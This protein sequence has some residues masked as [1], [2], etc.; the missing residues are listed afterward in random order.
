MNIQTC[1]SPSQFPLFSTNNT[2]VVVTDILRATSAMCTAFAN[3]IDK[4]IP[5]E[6]IEEAIK[7]KEQGYIVAA[8]RNGKI[9]EGFSLGN[10]PFDYM[11]EML[12]GKT[13]V[14]STTNGTQAIAAAKNAETI[15]IGAFVNIS[16][17]ADFLIHEQKD[18]I[19]L[20]A[21]W[22]NKF[23]IEDTLFAGALAQ[24]LLLNSTFKTD[25]DS[26]IAA[27]HLYDIAKSNMFGF[28]ENSSHRNRLKNLNLE[29]DINYCLTPDTCNV[30][31]IY[32]KNAITNMNLKTMEK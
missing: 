23:N 32:S 25:C 10:S 26:S 31:P 29:M 30:L 5:V 27:I 16:T 2:I 21:G 15:V 11:N 4:I 14:I 24:K 12:V 7:F 20:C 18:V 28:L 22:K 13:I 1:F 3:K 8:E 9:V 6:S 17:V 19:I